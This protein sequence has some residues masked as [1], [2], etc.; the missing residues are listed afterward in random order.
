MSIKKK[1]EFCFRNDMNDKRTK[2]TDNQA[3]KSPNKNKT[4]N[5]KSFT[6]S[7]D[8]PINYC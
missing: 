5:Q 7:A 6:V 4:Q 1:S 2:N 8:K 3:T